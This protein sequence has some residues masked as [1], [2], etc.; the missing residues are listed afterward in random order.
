MG[1]CFRH[2]LHI[3]LFCLY[4]GLPEPLVPETVNRDTTKQ[5][6]RNRRHTSSGSYSDWSERELGSTSYNDCWPVTSPGNDFVFDYLDGVEPTENDGKGVADIV[7]AYTG[8]YSFILPQISLLQ[9]K[10][11]VEV[12]FMT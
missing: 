4:K 10:H 3:D 12:F 9:N 11:P 2:V 8:E 7:K 1:P 6:N 5:L